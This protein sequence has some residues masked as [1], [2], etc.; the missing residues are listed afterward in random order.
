[1]KKGES[2]VKLR[3]RDCGHIVDQDFFKDWNEGLPIPK[4]PKCKGRVWM[5]VEE[6]EGN[7]QKFILIIERGEDTDPY[8][9]EEVEGILVD[10]WPQVSHVVFFEVLDFQ[11]RNVK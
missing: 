4:C 7:K 9:A 8:T 10:V 5:P 6:V 3:C 11:E 1:M 2:K